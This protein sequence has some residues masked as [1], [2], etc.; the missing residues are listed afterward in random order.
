MIVGILVP[1]DETRPFKKAQTEKPV[2]RSIDGSAD[3]IRALA[4]Q[5]GLLH[6][7]LERTV[8]AAFSD[9]KLVAQVIS[10]SEEVRRATTSLLTLLG[11]RQ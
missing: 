1:Q 5:A 6:T 7:L 2:V 3:A 10:L 11:G 8:A 4:E 9:R